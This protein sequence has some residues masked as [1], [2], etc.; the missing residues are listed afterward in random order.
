MVEGVYDS[1]SQCIVLEDVVTSGS[2]VLE[3]VSSLQDVGVAV[4]HV[5]A[6]VDREQGAELTLTNAGL[7]LHRYIMCYCMYKLHTCTVIVVC[8][9]GSVRDYTRLLVLTRVQTLA[10][11]SAAAVEVP[12]ALLVFMLRQVNC[13]LVQIDAV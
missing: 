2:S 11:K 4:K 5:V 3:T 13:K 1:D 9:I 12:Y 7:V 8:C 10:T 6:I